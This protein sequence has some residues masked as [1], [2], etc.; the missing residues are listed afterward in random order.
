MIRATVVAGFFLCAGTIAALAFTAKV[1]SGTTLNLPT[2]KGFCELSTSDPSEKRMLTL[3][4]K[5]AELNGNTMLTIAA[6]CKQ[7]ATWDA[8]K[9]Q[10]MDDLSN[11][12]MSPKLIDKTPEPIRDTCEVLRNQGDQ[13]TKEQTKGKQDNLAKLSR[14]L[15]INS[16]KFA[17]VLDEDANA[18]YSGFLQKIHTEIGTDRVTMT[19]LAISVVRQQSVFFYRQGLFA[20]TD[21]SDR[22]L[23][24]TKDT[25][26]ALYAANP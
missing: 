4:G 13:L 11:Y 1:G 16:E 15:A 14:E 3:L 2:P 18:C 23:A 8:G 6:D 21:P 26:A 12:Q 10:L 22:L 20:D 5:N 7:L 17:G 19:I 24:H 9:R 25:I